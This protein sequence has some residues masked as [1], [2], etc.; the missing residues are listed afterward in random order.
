MIK[1]G[2][3]QAAVLRVA[4]LL[5]RCS[6][7]VTVTHEEI[8][9]V[10]RGDEIERRYSIVNRARDL[11][12]KQSGV[13]FSTVNREGV[14]RLGGA[15]GADYIGGKTLRLIRHASNRG[16]RRLENAVHHANDL[17][18]EQRRVANARLC[19]LGLIRHLTLARTVKTMPDEPPP[20][21]DGLS[22]LRRAMGM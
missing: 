15:D 10:L 4:E 9:S 20:Q 7:S 6:I 1:Q 17:S 11:L 3:D 2:K 21:P 19:S 14:R 13:V 5:A 8:K 12:N 18:P 16:T 22:E